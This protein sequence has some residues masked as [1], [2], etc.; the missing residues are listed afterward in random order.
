MLGDIPRCA[1]TSEGGE[2]CVRRTPKSRQPEGK[3]LLTK[4][5]RNQ[6]K[7]W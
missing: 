4:R 6:N 7:R 2:C 5:C 3:I 1:L